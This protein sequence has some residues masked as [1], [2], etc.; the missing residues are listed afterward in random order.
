MSWTIDFL[1]LHLT[2]LTFAV[3]L[4]AISS[5][6]HLVTDMR[7]KYSIPQML[8]SNNHTVAAAFIA[9]LKGHGLLRRPR[10]IHRSLRRKF[11]YHQSGCS[12]SEIPSFWTDVAR[13]SRHQSNIAL[14]VCKMG[15]TARLH[16]AKLDCTGNNV[17]S[18]F[19]EQ[20][21]KRG[22][23]FS[24]LWPLQRCI[25]SSMLKRE[26]FN[27]QSLTNKSSFI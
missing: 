23:D 20:D 4:M 2:V 21:I 11:V 3:W 9:A 10:Y 15:I 12:A 5:R 24:V 19:I 27:A 26:L 14:G 6:T 25:T 22:V 17:I 1:L 18:L 8:N 13:L 7:L 16:N